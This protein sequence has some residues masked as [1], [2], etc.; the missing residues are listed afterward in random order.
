MCVRTIEFAA[1]HRF[2]SRT[3][4]DLASFPR[5]STSILD[6]TRLLSRR[7]T[8]STIFPNSP[9]NPKTSHSNAHPLSTTHALSRATVLLITRTDDNSFDRYRVL[10]HHVTR[11]LHICDCLE[12]ILQS[13][14][15]NHRYVFHQ[16]N[17][18]LSQIVALVLIANS[19]SNLPQ[20]TTMAYGVPAPGGRMTSMD[21][22]V[23]GKYR[24]GKKIG[25]GS[26]G[27]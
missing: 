4:A 26:F 2:A 5:T 7:S 3:S 16:H 25:S 17:Q 18:H 9:N 23:G 12:R 15:G 6:T 14:F 20:P 19:V 24:I 1:S 11:N 27:K 13:L 22:R 8:C 10:L 21:L